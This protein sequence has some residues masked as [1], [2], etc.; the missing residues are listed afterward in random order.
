MLPYLHVQVHFKIYLFCRTWFWHRFSIIYFFSCWKY[1]WD[2]ARSLSHYTK[3]PK[4]EPFH[5]NSHHW[6]LCTK[7][8]NCWRKATTC[9]WAGLVWMRGKTMM[10]EAHHIQISIRHFT[11]H[12][13]E[14]S[15]SDISI[16]L[17]AA[18]K[19]KSKVSINIQI[20]QF[21]K[22]NSFVY[23]NLLLI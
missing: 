6:C 17:G 1:V 4:S 8:I 16:I 23:W 12:K 3:R 20:S 22:K 9:G 2:L 5:K 21:P 14:P 11:S 19:F 13:S 10:L 18:N 15:S 7:L